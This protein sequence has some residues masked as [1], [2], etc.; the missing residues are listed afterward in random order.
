[1]SRTTHSSVRFLSLKSG[2]L[3]EQGTLLTLV[4]QDDFGVCGVECKTISKAAEEIVGD[5]D[6]DIA[7]ALWKVPMLC[8]LSALKYHT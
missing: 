8:C 3:C 6:T 1:M 5:A 2:S 4:E 7:E